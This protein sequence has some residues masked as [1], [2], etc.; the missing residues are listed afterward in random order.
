MKER[1]KMD[2]WMKERTEYCSV[3][4]QPMK[5]QCC[6]WM[7]CCIFPAVSVT[8]VQIKVESRR[9]GGTKKHRNEGREGGRVI[10]RE[11][12]WEDGEER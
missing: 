6:W 7:L 5:C 9:R 1:T 11:E 8:L 2:G 3:P 4:A 10:Y 12:R